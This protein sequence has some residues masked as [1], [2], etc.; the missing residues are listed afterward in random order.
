MTIVQALLGLLIAC[1]VMLVIAWRASAR[2]HGQATSL[3][4]ALQSLIGFV[5]NFFD[6]LGI[7]S[8]ATTTAAFRLTR[9]VPDELIPGTL[10]V[11]LALPVIAQALIFLTVVEVNPVQMAT[12]IACCVAG[13][14]LGAGVVASIS[15]RA[16]QLAMAVALTA[17]AA[18][19]LAGMFGLFPA[20]GTATTFSP[21]A[22]AMAIGVNLVLGALLT[23]G[24]G[25]YA[26]SLIVFSLLGMD[27]RAAFPIMMGSGAFVATVAG[28]R[29]IARARFDSRAALGLTLGGIPGVLIAAWLVQSLPLDALRWVVLVVVLHSAVSLLRASLRGAPAQAPAHGSAAFTPPS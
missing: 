20:G 27:P 14:W 4:R 9:L 1:G 12:L 16:I 24:I 2:R 26:P 13:G 7:G 21:S 25:N 15:K 10:L 23:I 5:V 22:F 17:A 18:L 28:A 3:P 11:G 19:M 6:T 29:F 8:F